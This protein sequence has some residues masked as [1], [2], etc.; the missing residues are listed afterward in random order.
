MLLAFN[1]YLNKVF[2][3]VAYVVLVKHFN[4]TGILI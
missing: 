1:N 4:F 2:V 3:W